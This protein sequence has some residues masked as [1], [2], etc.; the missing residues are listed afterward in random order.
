MN[1]F[2]HFTAPIVDDD[3]KVYNIHF[4]ALFS[5][6]PDAIPIVLLHG[7]PGSF[8]ALLVASL[9]KLRLPTGSFLE[10]LPILGLVSARYEAASDL[11]YHLIVPSLPGYGFS[12][13]P[14]MD[15]RF[16][17]ADVARLCDKLMVGLGFEAYVAQGGDIGS[18]IA[19]IMAA[20]YKNCKGTYSVTLAVIDCNDSFQP[21]TSTSAICPK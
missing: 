20:T 6:K 10:F 17:H 12:S 13:P 2:P 5:K 11:P 7:W 8:Q 16:V 21:F 9:F 1:S 14:P 4:V 15:R 18:R 3:G 19:R